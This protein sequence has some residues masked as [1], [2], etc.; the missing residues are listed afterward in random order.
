[1]MTFSIKHVD[2]EVPKGHQVDCPIGSQIYGFEAQQRGVDWSH[3]YTD[4]NCNYKSVSQEKSRVGN[5]KRV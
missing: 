3:Q 2:Y 5:E 4:C 1:M